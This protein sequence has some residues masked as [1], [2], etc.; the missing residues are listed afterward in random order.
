MNLLRF[1][2]PLSSAL[3]STSVCHTASQGRCKCHTDVC[4]TFVVLTRCR[5]SCG[6]AEANRTKAALVLLLV[7]SVLQ[8]R[9][10]PSD[11]FACRIIKVLSEIKFIQSKCDVSVS[12]GWASVQ[13]KFRNVLVEKESAAVWINSSFR[14]CCSIIIYNILVFLW[15]SSVMTWK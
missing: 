5:A 10:V 1:G 15:M 12:C 2:I 8:N 14:F 7:L 3:N 9:K 4:W 13:E 11:L 6:F